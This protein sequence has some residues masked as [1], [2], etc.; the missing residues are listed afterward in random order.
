[1]EGKVIANKMAKEPSCKM[2]AERV[3]DV[4]NNTSEEMGRNA[5]KKNIFDWF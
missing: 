5:W 2:V 3:L 4:Y 1:M